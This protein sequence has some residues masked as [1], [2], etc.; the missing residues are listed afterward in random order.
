MLPTE[1]LTSIERALTED[2]GTGDATTNSIVP[3]DATMR[4]QIIAKQEGVVAGLEV[5]R[6]VYQILDSN[7]G[8]NVQVEDGSRVTKGQVL[9]FVSGRARCSGIWHCK[10]GSGG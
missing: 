4:G 8:F 7:L 2:I 6:A 9:A 10:G 5:A 3:V 1:I